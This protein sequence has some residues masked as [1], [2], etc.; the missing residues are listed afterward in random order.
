[1]AAVR[2]GIR[3]PQE[4]RVHQIPVAEE[5]GLAGPVEQVVLLV[6]AGESPPQ[7]APVRTHGPAVTVLPGRGMGRGEALRVPPP[8]V[9][10]LMGL[11]GLR[12]HHRS[13]PLRE[14]RSAGARPRET[15]ISV[16]PPGPAR[17]MGLAGRRGLLLMTTSAVAGVPRP[18]GP[19]GRLERRRE[20][21]IAAARGLL[22][23]VASVAALGLRRARLRQATVRADRRGLLRVVA[24]A[25]R[26]G[27]RRAT[28]LV[29]RAG[30][31]PADRAGP[32]SETRVQASAAAHPVVT[33]EAMTGPPR[34]EATRGAGRTREVPAPVRAGSGL[35]TA[36]RAGEILTPPARGPMLAGPAAVAL[37]AAVLVPATVPG[38]VPGVPGRVPLVPLTGRRVLRRIGHVLPLTGRRVLR[39]IGHV[40]RRIGRS[41]GAVRIAHPRGRLAAVLG[42][43][44]RAMALVM[45]VVTAY[46]RR[47]AE[48][49]GRRHDPAASGLG[50]DRTRR[51]VPGVQ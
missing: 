35:R 2:V 51:A 16:T 24:S 28:G 27:P 13:A 34:Q 39:R 22:P 49:T 17:V 26:P 32:R 25:A 50:P 45:G 40:L 7:A 4:A 44:R 14:T 42:Q 5:P 29:A 8:A 12:A 30:L 11:V 43:G 41:A 3:R 36:T 31:R 21:S 20:A 23:T 18:T 10:P 37:M 48:A 6:T 33:T 15:A 19:E 1:V 46:R 9:L 47:L 38:P